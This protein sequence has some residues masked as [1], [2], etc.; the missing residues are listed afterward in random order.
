M[1]VNLSGQ[2]HCTLHL[3]SVTKGSIAGFHKDHGPYTED[4]RDLKEQIEELIRKGKL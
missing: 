4:C 2:D 1:T 3:M